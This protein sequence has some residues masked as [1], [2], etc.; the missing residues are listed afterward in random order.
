VMTKEKTEA[1]TLSLGW[2]VYVKMLLP[3][4]IL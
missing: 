3:S 2:P 1:A 4:Q